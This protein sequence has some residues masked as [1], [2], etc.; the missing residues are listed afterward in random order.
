[1]IKRYDPSSSRQ[2]YLRINADNA[3]ETLL[4][5]YLLTAF[6]AKRWASLWLDLASIG[7]QR[8]WVGSRQGYLEYRDWVIK[9]FNED[10]PYD[11]FLEEQL[12]GDLLPDPTEAQYIATAFSR[13][14]L[15]NDEGGTDNEEFRT[16][17]VLD[18][19]N[20]TWEALM[21]TTFSC[22][23][24]TVI[25]TL[26]FRQWILRLLRTL[27]IP[28]TGSSPEYPFLRTFNET[29]KASWKL[30]AGKIMARK[31]SRSRNCFCELCNLLCMN[32]AIVLKRAYRHNKGHWFNNHGLLP[33]KNNLSWI[34]HVMFNFYMEKAAECSLLTLFAWCA[35]LEWKSFSKNLKL[36]SFTPR[37]ITGIISFP[38][39]VI[40]SILILL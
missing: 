22:V 3:Y 35:L 24:C 23:Q 8:L 16:A 27:T 20:V 39:R 15:T 25:L 32:Y 34:D 1:M 21:G 17:A 11:K 19:V 12:A 33:K 28:A 26:P 7:Q 36:I 5:R 13:N 29:L 18:R 2:K 37:V 40:T 14:S 38:S 10:K 6:W 9:A 30:Q 31:K 4:I